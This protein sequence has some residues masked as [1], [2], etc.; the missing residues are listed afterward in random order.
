[1]EAVGGRLFDEGLYGCIFTPTL[2]CKPGSRRGSITED[3]DAL[4]PPISKLI[5]SD[6]AELEF[7]ISKMIRKIPLW[8]NYFVVS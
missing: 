4:H 1:M 3:K 7:S 6:D 5:L 8:K 2:D